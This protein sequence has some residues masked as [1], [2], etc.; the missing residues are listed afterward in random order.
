[1]ADIAVFPLVASKTALVQSH[2]ALLHLHLRPGAS[3]VTVT[4]GLQVMTGVA[5]N[6]QIVGVKLVIENH[7]GAGLIVGL[8]NP[9]ARCL[10]RSILPFVGSE[11]IT[12]IGKIGG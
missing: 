5:A 11:D 12:G 4:A 9:L 2:L 1:V 8:E 3:L 10:L 6:L 7:Q